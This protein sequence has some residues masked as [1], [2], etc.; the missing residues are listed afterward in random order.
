M[1]KKTKLKKKP[2]FNHFEVAIIKEIGKNRR[3][4]TTNEIS[5]NTGISWITCQKYIDRLFGEGI[6]ARQFPNKK[7]VKIYTEKKR[8]YR[9][10]FE[11]LYNNPNY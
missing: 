10:N 4:M 3:F 7:G 8:K 2:L 5:K 6:I 11:K 1:K 9:I